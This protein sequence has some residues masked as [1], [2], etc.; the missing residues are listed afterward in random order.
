MP[1]AAPTGTARELLGGQ[2][3]ILPENMPLRDAA[4]LLLQEHLRA[5]PVVDRDGKYLGVLS[6]AD[7]VQPTDPGDDASGMARTVRRAACP[8][9]ARRRQIDG[10][11]TVVCALP[12]GICPVRVPRDAAG[13]AGA[14]CNDPGDEVLDWQV[15]H[16]ERLPTEPVR[17]FATAEPLVAR[18]DEALAVLSGRLLESH[19]RRVV[20]IDDQQRPCALVGRGEVRAALQR[21][22]RPS[23]ERPSEE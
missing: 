18:A 22:E 3:L 17:R 23:P 1:A 14:L 19:A 11:E 4:R 15:A 16:V 13:S 7:A 5:A 9:R 8:F 21:L 20:I 12:T 2:L 6:A 10:T